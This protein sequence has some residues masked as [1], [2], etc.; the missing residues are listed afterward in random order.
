M[1]L[2][3]VLALFGDVNFGPSVDNNEF[4]YVPKEKKAKPI[5]KIEENPNI[6]II[7]GILFIGLIP[8]DD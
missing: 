7:D 8:E 2:F 6:E 3:N 4:I 5:I 1:W